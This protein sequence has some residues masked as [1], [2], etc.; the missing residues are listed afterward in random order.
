MKV[1]EAI[2]ERVGNGMEEPDF[3]AP[4]CSDWQ[5]AL[6]ASFEPALL[7]LHS[8]LI[9]EELWQG[10][11]M[12]LQAALEIE[13]VAMALYPAEKSAGI[14]RVTNSVRDLQFD[15]TNP[16]AT[17]VLQAL[18]DQ[19]SGVSVLRV[20]HDGTEGAVVE[21]TFGKNVSQLVSSRFACLMIFCDRARILGWLWL[22]R[23]ATQPGFTSK[24]MALLAA[25]YI[26]FNI[27]AQRVC[28]FEKERETTS[29]HVESERTDPATLLLDERCTPVFHNRA[30]VNICALWTGPDKARVPKLEFVLPEEIRG[31]C[32]ALYTNWQRRAGKGRL[33]ESLTRT[34]AHASGFSANVQLLRMGRPPTAKTLFL[35]HLAQVGRGE[36]HVSAL[37]L[38]QRLTASERDIAKLVSWGLD[39][40]QIA[41]EHCIAINTVRAHLNNIFHK[42]GVN[43]RGEL[44]VLLGTAALITN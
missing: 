34:V 6:P 15:F 31:A 9:V 12:A 29:V 32:Q 43:S 2:A 4:E 33:A 30:A 16:E 21:S 23:Q 41:T 5:S 7:A 1:S 39:N 40:Q 3:F 44:S 13:D 11:L 36:R 35:V 37:N 25:L 10:V 18:L 22:N 14:L 27:A 24:D 20:P 19:C 28:R 38:L 26:Q 17:S 42:L 8:A